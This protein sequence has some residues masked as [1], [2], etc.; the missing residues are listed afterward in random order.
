MLST[1][2]LEKTDY[3]TEFT[4]YIIKTENEFIYHNVHYVITKQ[5]YLK[6][7]VLSCYILFLHEN[8]N[9]FFFK[10]TF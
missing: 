1:F 4:E 3:L 9:F 2:Q 7:N 8:R 5:N 6:K 10:K